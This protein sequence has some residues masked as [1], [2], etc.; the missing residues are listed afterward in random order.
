MDRSQ[1]IISIIV[2]TLNEESSLTAT[3]NLAQ[4]SER[5]EIIVVDG[6]SSDQ[7][8]EIAHSL[9]VKVVS[10]QA[11]RAGQMNA[12]AREARGDILLFLHADTLLP[13]GYDKCIHRILRDRSVALGAFR[14]GIK[15]QGISFRIIEFG[16]NLRSRY[17]NLPY[18]DQAFFMRRQRFE[19]LGGF[20]EISLMEDF[21]LVRQMKKLGRVALA[22]LA[23][24]TSARRWQKEGILQTTVLNQL[25]VGA[26]M[27]GVSPVRLAAWY[28]RKTGRHSHAG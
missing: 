26:Y 4:K 20:P 18:G 23:V 8:L 21:A 22:P 5:I 28:R 27:M 3:I 10:S 7:T 25:I 24:Q 15:A 19:Q 1:D 11:G 14:L 12:G 16:A 2:P 13:E 6:G 9:Q 17:C